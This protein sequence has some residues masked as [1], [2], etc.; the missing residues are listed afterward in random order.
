ML[1]Q[2]LCHL[3]E[4]ANAE[5]FNDAIK[6]YSCISKVDKRLQSLFSVLLSNMGAS[7]TSGTSKRSKLINVS[8]FKFS[9]FFVYLSIKKLRVIF[10]Y[11]F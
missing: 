6:D 8:L 9:V 4:D 5:A 3:V 7:G 10:V 1:F 11:L 2:T